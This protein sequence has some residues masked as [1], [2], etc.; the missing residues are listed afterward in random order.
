MKTQGVGG[1]NVFGMSA[2]KALNERDLYI[3]IIAYPLTSDILAAD[4][5]DFFSAS[6]GLEALDGS[7]NNVL[8][9]V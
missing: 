7:G 8:L 3:F 1:G 2:G 4:R 6:H 5:C 9:V